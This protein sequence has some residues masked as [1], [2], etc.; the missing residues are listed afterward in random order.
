M[1]LIHTYFSIIVYL[2]I[3]FS[4][5]ITVIIV[6][7]QI[8]FTSSYVSN[9]ISCSRKSEKFQDGTNEDVSEQRLKQEKTDAPG[10][11]EVAAHQRRNRSGISNLVDAV[12]H[13]D[14][15]S[16]VHQSGRSR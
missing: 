13:D 9:E 2:I 3:Y 10:E 1:F 6:I 11:N 5:S 7:C 8:D 14:D 4:N 15:N 12:L 16:P